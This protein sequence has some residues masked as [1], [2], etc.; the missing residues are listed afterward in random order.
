M[1]HNPDCLAG[2]HFQVEIL[3]CPDYV[4]ARVPPEQASDQLPYEE[5]FA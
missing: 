2:P 5:R 3:E 1:A 4:R